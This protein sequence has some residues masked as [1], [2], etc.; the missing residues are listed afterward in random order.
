MLDLGQEMVAPLKHQIS[1]HDPLLHTDGSNEGQ[2]ID[3]QNQA[4]VSGFSG[5]ELTLLPFISVT[6]N[7]LICALQ[8]KIFKNHMNGT[9]TNLL[10]IMWTQKFNHVICDL[11]LNPSVIHCCFSLALTYDFFLFLCVKV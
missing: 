4:Q 1:P 2:M 8:E 7:P 3:E 5:R 6:S 9:A 10:A 11:I